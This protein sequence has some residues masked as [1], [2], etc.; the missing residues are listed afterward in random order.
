MAPGVSSAKRESSRTIGRSRS[1][2]FLRGY[3]TGGYIV[4][5]S[6]EVA[7]K[8]GGN[9]KTIYVIKCRLRLSAKPQAIMCI[10]QFETVGRG[11]FG[12]EKPEAAPLAAGG[13]EPPS[14]S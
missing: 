10:T 9:D 12:R 6:G 14:S 13:G 7:P 3:P 8:Q 5:I 11:R 2:G 4:S 1:H